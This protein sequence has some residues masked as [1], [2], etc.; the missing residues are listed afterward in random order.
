M[1]RP[2]TRKP[3]ARS[4]LRRIGSLVPRVAGKALGKRGF[5]QIEILSRWPAIVGAELARE[6]RP[7]KIAFSRGK[8][9]D[10]G[11]LHLRVSGALA[12]ELQ[13]LEPILLERINQYY[14]YPAL[15]RIK[16]IHGPIEQPARPEPPPP[17]RDLSPAEAADVDRA[18]AGTKDP[19]LKAALAGLGRAI[20]GGKAASGN[21]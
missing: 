20:R 5:A 4:G 15:T 17:E 14:G 8:S 12:P 10:G 11:V 13:H 2:P 7:V 16:L 19:G 6:C 3:A 18:V 1:A 21:E 9:A